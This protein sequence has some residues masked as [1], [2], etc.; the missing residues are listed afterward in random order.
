MGI[1][2]KRGLHLFEN[3][4]TIMLGKVGRVEI[5]CL[6]P[7]MTPQIHIDTI[8]STR[9]LANMKILSMRTA[10][11]FEKSRFHCSQSK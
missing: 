6:A 5:N 2:V 9:T 3:D 11:R 10:P 8:L 1:A 7:V 4:R